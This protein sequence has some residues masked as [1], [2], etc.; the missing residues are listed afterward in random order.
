MSIY[1]I[2]YSPDGQFFEVPYHKF[3]ELV[4]QKGWTQTKPE[5]EPVKVASAPA[6]KKKAT[7]RSRAPTKVFKD[8]DAV[9]EDTTT[10]DA[11]E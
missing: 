7:S 6:K 2:V 4:L 11:D 10:A 1:H 3:Q 9:Q 8:F 5:P